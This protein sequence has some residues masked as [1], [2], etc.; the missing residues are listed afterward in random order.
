MDLPGNLFNYIKIAGIILAIL[1]L[2]KFIK[3][4]FNSAKISEVIEKSFA[5][6]FFRQFFKKS[7]YAGKAKKLIRVGNYQDAGR[8]FEEIGDFASAITAYEK[9]QDWFSLANL[10]EKTKST[11]KA[12]IY[13]EKAGYLHEAVRIYKDIDNKKKAAKL[14]E[15]NQSYE[16]AAELYFESGD[17]ESAIKLYKKFGYYN[18]VG[19]TYEKLN[20]WEKAA[21]A[22]YKWFNHLNESRVMSVEISNEVIKYLKKASELYLK[23]GQSEKAI[24]ILEEEGLYDEAAKICE[25][26][27]RLKK[28]AKLYELNHNYEKASQIYM[29]LND[30]TKANLMLADHHYE[31]GNTLE[32]AQYFFMAGDYGRAGELF[33]WERKYRKAAEAFERNE[34]YAAAAQNYSRVK[35]KLK[36]AELYSK[37]GEHNKAGEIYRDLQKLQEAAEEFSNGKDHL[38]AGLCFYD[39]D[40]PQKAIEA[41]QKVDKEHPDFSKAIL[42][43]G[44]IFH[45][46]GKLDLAIN[47]LKEFLKENKISQHNIAHYYIL[48]K[49]YQKASQYEQAIDVYKSI[50]SVT[51]N[52]KDTQKLI[53]ESYKWLSK[54]KEREIMNSKEGVDKRYRIIEK[55]GEGGMGIVYKAEDN[56]LKR[57]VALKVLKKSIFGSEK[58]INRFYSEARLAAK[59]NHPNVVTI[60]DV[61][62]FKEQ[63]FISME[64]IEGDNFITFLKKKKRLTYQQTLFV[65]LNLF[66]AL[67]YAHKK[68]IIHR[69]IKPQNIMLTKDKQIKIMDFGLA[70]V[71]NKM[72]TSENIIAGNPTYMSPE[73]IKGENIDHRTDIYSSGI[74]LFHLVVGYPPFRGENTAQ[75]HLYNIAPRV[76]EIKSTIPVKFSDFIAKSIEKNKEKRFLSSSEALLKLKRIMNE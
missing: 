62:R 19:K 32:A 41:F 53:E 40:N 43:I 20:K 22:Y 73:Q 7:Y 67:E 15:K 6:T 12:A 13:Y 42:F 16:E 44:K 10:F 25:K 69:D 29:K 47:T 36:A 17:F 66:R 57:I 45:A 9:S 59:M 71:V 58:T 35:E 21:E 8:I 64:H 50:Q 49:S 55:I 46:S 2:I 30:E 14:L 72:E 27:N 56:L 11:E 31:S 51:F 63:P 39:I 52:Y 26:N 3:S 38:N 28:A 24:K 1:I 23:C 61:G 60:Y 68:E 74:T 54:K 33:E 4:L 18:Y 48:G 70:V 65:A 75:Q 76:N 37:A 5:S 34:S